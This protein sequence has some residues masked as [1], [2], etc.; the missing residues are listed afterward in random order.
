MMN[1]REWMIPLVAVATLLSAAPDA[2]AC[3][4]A[5]YSEFQVADV[6]TAD[7]IAISATDP[8]AVEEFGVTVTAADGE[9]HSGTID[10]PDQGLGLFLWRPDVP[11]E[12][13]E[14]TVQIS[15]FGVDTVESVLVDEGRDPEIDFTMTP[16]EKEVP[17]GYTCCETQADG[18]WD[19]CGGDCTSCWPSGYDYVPQTELTISTNQ[20]VLVS[21]SMHMPGREEAVG[22]SQTVLTERT[23]TF[24]RG[25][26]QPVDGEVCLTVQA[27][28]LGGENLFG[29]TRCFDTAELEPLPRRTPDAPDAVAQCAVPPADTDDINWQRYGRKGPLGGC[30]TAS[31]RRPSSLIPG[32]LLCIVLVLGRRRGVHWER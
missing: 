18:C 8:W 22:V 21:A 14:Y 23:T 20:P 25:M 2:D 32:L 3:S 31:E 30:N 27:Q 5:Y 15:S 9:E 17:S 10:W 29:E 19:D 1:V 12:L 11:L 26:L 16:R 6:G 28:S 13:G 7:Q 24:E 4:V